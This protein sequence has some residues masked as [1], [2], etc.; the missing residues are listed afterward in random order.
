[1]CH[2]ISDSLTTYRE[3]ITVLVVVYS[4]QLLG[5]FRFGHEHTMHYC[6]LLLK[7]NKNSMQ[8]I[9][10]NSKIP[11]KVFF[12]QISNTLQMIWL[13]SSLVLLLYLLIS[14]LGCDL[15]NVDKRIIS[16]HCTAHV[17]VDEVKNY[18]YLY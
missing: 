9:A 4:M 10:P 18:A 3:C 12:F 1:M 11:R 15:T 6:S 14:H 13:S 17:A 8:I 16:C 2:S 5:H 7:L